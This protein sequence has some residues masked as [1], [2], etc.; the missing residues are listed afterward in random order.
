MTPRL[1]ATLKLKHPRLTALIATV[2]F[3]HLTIPPHP[4][5]AAAPLQSAYND[6]STAAPYPVEDLTGLTA[7]AVG[8]VINSNTLMVMVQGEFKKVRLIGVEAP[9]DDQAASDATLFL[10]SL[11]KGEQVYVARDERLPLLDKNGRTWAYVY[12]VPDG[13][14]VN[15]ELIRQGYTQAT[16][17][18]AHRHRE[19]FWHYHRRAH[20]IRR[21]FTQGHEPQAQTPGPDHKPAPH[22]NMEWTTDA[23]MNQWGKDQGWHWSQNKTSQTEQ[24]GLIEY[25]A[26]TVRGELPHIRIT[27]HPNRLQ[28]II[29]AASIPDTSDTD[30]EQFGSDSE[31][32]LYKASRF[33][34]ALTGL[35]AESFARWASA[36][37]YHFIKTKTQKPRAS[38]PIV[39]PSTP[40][41]S[42]VFYRDGND[43]GLAVSITNISGEDTAP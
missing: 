2:C 42:I 21:V 15:L 13:Y 4:C 5:S 20:R 29:Y 9:D 7:Y 10:A 24:S 30:L 1:H 8:P 22:R 11:L 19:L 34:S 33:P 43:I 6:T 39:H 27:G 23:V 28:S 12:R 18:Q 16:P 38:Q 17:H 25:T 35:D 36:Q 31:L 37:L 41:V 3:T 14:F 40:E 26:R 32:C